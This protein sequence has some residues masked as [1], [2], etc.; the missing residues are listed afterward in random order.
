MERDILSLVMMVT[1]S[2]V[3]AAAAHAKSKMDGSALEDHQLPKIL[4]AKT[5]QLKSLLP[6]VGNPTNG[7]ESFLMSELTIFHLLL[8][9]LPMIAQTI[10]RMS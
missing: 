3:M 1:Q 9:N 4:V 8:F 7:E 5:S 6:Q 10:A 2:M